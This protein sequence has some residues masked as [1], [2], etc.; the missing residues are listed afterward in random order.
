MSESLWQPQLEGLLHR[1]HSQPTLKAEL[2]G[3]ISPGLHAG[4]SLSPKFSTGKGR[5]KYIHFQY[6]EN[7]VQAVG[8]PRRLHR[9]QR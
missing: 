4:V 3:S 7:Q 1:I 5:T 6:T 9:L 8:I 2:G